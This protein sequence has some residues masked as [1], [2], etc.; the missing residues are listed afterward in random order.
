NQDSSNDREADFQDSGNVT[1]QGTQAGSDRFAAF[2]ASRT[3]RRGARASL[4]SHASSVADF[5][6]DSLLSHFDSFP[7]ASSLSVLDSFARQSST[8]YSSSIP[9]SRLTRSRTSSARA[10]ASSARAPSP[11][12]TMKF[13]CT[14]ET[15]ALPLRVPFIPI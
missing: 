10:N 6:G 5:V 12:V 8:S 15:R 4:S 13:A 14:G 7:F 3:L 2:T 1:E 9:C 11:S